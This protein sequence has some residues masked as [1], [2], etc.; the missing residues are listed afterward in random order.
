MSHVPVRVAD[1]VDSWVPIPDAV[2]AVD[3]LAVIGTIGFFGPAA[4]LLA[5]VTGALVDRAGL[6]GAREG[7]AVV[8]PAHAN[9]I[10]NE[11]GASARQIRALIRRCQTA[12]GERFGVALREEIVCLGFRPGTGE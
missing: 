8:S 2:L 3:G 1:S 11:G 5:I 12:V 7:R 4:A 6:K 10:V 9:F